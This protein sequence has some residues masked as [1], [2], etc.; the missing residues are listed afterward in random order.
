VREGEVGEEVIRVA[1]YAV[2]AGAAQPVTASRNGEV[3]ELR[4]EPFEENPQV[5]SIFLV[6]DLALDRDAPLYLDVGP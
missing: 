5:E 4:L 1:H 6:D 3:I 2:Q